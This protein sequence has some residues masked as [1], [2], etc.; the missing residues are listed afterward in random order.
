MLIR[1]LASSTVLLY[2]IALLVT[3]I[4]LLRR[5]KRVR[6]AI[7]IILLFWRG[8]FADIGGVIFDIYRISLL[9]FAL[10]LP[11]RY[12]LRD[13]IIAVRS[14]WLSLITFIIFVCLVSLGYYFES[15]MLV[16]A[17]MYKY[18]IP[19]AI[20]PVMLRL[21]RDRQNATQLNRLFKEILLVQVALTVVKLALIGG[22]YE[23]LVGS[24]TG[25]SGGGVGTTLPLLGLCLFTL[26]T[27]MNIKSRGSIL[28]L[29][30]MLS[31][32]WMTGKRAVW[33]LF[34]LLFALLGL[35]V[36]KSISVK[37]LVPLVALLPLFIY[38]GL[39]L[40]PTL[41]PE[42]KI[43][44]SFNP[45]YAWN[46]AVDYSAGK[47]DATTGERIEG[48]GRIG[49]NIL[50]YNS[51]FNS[52][53]LDISARL[54]GVGIGHVFNPKENSY[55]DR[56]YYMGVAHRGA[57]TGFGMFVISFGV[58]G[59]ILFFLY[60]FRIISFARYKNIRYL[61]GGVMLFDFIFYNSTI[62]QQPSLMVLMMFVII[63][64]NS[65]Y[66]KDGRY[67]GT[68]SITDKRG[69]NR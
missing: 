39:R 60:L 26:N 4:F 5:Y 58:I 43:W 12:N 16:F 63:Y 2:D 62:V 11:F 25:V 67:I 33:L 42:G 10:Y 61:F 66:T 51:F 31:I 45:E 34:P 48:N 22:W 28:F 40:S 29:F 23:G 9:G 18:I 20:F 64:S 13:E 52:S 69:S 27:N 68:F 24:I 7:F 53:D 44:G 55:R 30:S 17:Q 56:D 46:Y 59:V 15:P 8:L 37:R 21:R 38:F 1:G 54:M 65:V 49:A 57:L 14:L 32:G 35:F 36:S 47:A 19:A 41:N 3:L 6:V 50:L